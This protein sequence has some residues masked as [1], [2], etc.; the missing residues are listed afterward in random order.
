MSGST[1]F[2]FEPGQFNHFSL[3]SFMILFIILFRPQS[4]ASI[5]TI[6]NESRKLKTVRRVYPFEQL[7]NESSNYYPSTLG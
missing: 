2:L 4:L 3:Y 1:N 5:L 6:E 7:S